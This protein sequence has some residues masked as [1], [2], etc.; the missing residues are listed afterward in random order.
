MPHWS[1]SRFMVYE[2]C[3]AEF[4]A[5]YVD[6]VAIESTEAM[7]FGQA[8]HMGLEAHYN[9]QDG[10]RAFR[11]AWQVFQEQ[12]VADGQQV[13][14]ALTGMGLLLL[15]QV[16]DLDLRGVPERGFSLDTE[17]VLG[18]PI[19]GAIDLWADGGRTLYDFKTTRGQW[20]A[21][22]AQTER[23]QPL[24]YSWA[25]LEETG[26]L[27]TFEY[28]VCNRASGQVDRYQRRWD[29]DSWS[30]LWA[31][32]YERMRAISQAVAG[33]ALE[34]HGKHGPCPECGE[35]WMH[36]HVCDETKSRRIRL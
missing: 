23:W 14:P 25:A 21:E 22:R 7:S 2:Q 11:A 20:S 9:G 19:I 24:L 13:K 18:A 28:I 3:P 1:A 16:V 31:T 17:L 15:E 29:E 26:E 10:E 12:L 35:R 6:G 34:C 4:R 36:G 8:V 27:P 33:D 30:K 5:R 32:S